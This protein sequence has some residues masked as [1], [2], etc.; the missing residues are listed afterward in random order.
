M[1]T[2]DGYQSEGEELSMGLAWLA[3]ILIVTGLGLW[4]VIIF[5]AIS[6]F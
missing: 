5:M 4:W 6:G 2:R 3:S 1:K